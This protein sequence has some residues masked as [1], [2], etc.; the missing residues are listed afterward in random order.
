MA[1]STEQKF[2]EE[3][4]FI[5]TLCLKAMILVLRYLVLH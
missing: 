1:S 2:L 3:Q 4:T 5:T